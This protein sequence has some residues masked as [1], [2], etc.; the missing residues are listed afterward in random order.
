MKKITALVGIVFSLAT[1]PLYADEYDAKLNKLL[2]ELDAVNQGL[3][4]VADSLNPYEV[5]ALALGEKFDFDA[6]KTV[7]FVQKKIDFDSYAGMLR[8]EKGTLLSG[9]GNALDQSILLAVMLGDIGYDARIQNGLLSNG[10]A[11][12]LLMQMFKRTA[13]LSGLDKEKLEQGMKSIAAS[14][15]KPTDTRWIENID[16]AFAFSDEFENSTSKT[17]QI[18]YRMLQSNQ[19]KQANPHGYEA[20]L[21]EAKNYY[22]VEYKM[23]PQ[24]DWK[25]AHPAF[26][27]SMQPKKLPEVIETFNSSIPEKLQHRVRIELLVDIVESGKLK[28]RSLMA[29]F[30]RPAGN[31]AGIPLKFNLTPNNSSSKDVI[32]KSQFFIPQFNESIPA[33]A[34][35]FHKLGLLVDPKDIAGEVN[36]AA[37]LFASMAESS[38]EASNSLGS[39]GGGGDRVTQALASVYLQVTIISPGKKNLVERHFWLNRVYDKKNDKDFKLTKLPEGIDLFKKLTGS[40]TLMIG[41]GR[42]KFGFAVND[43]ATKVAEKKPFIELIARKSRWPDKSVEF[44]F[45]EW[46]SMPVGWPL[47]NLFMSQLLFTN[48]T[49][50]NSV[51]YRDAPFIAL[52]KQGASYLD[53]NGSIIDIISNPVRAYTT[54]Q[55]NI[56]WDTERVLKQGV[57]DTFNESMFS[58][59]DGYNAGKI[60]LDTL[61]ESQFI[62]KVSQIEALPIKNTQVKQ[63][64]TADVNL[65]YAILLPNQTKLERPGWWRINSSTGQVLGMIDNGLGG[66]FIEDLQL[67]INVNMAMMGCLDASYMKADVDKCGCAVAAGM[68]LFGSAVGN[69]IDNK[70]TIGSIHWGISSTLNNVFGAN[71]SPNICD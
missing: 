44:G 27:Q 21:K 9:S 58:G 32:L 41:V 49:K 65:G 25:T 36:G 54:T 6:N 35:A 17:S 19:T 1:T 52:H 10:D 23:G 5:D 61:F 47:A 68:F 57:Y 15:S 71:Y 16:T 40:I 69:S 48:E 13:F 53:E 43:Y 46:S 37:G 55:D 67:R 56:R 26:G 2:S 50:K 45:K 12:Q 63:A 8:G 14:T 22:W 30:E 20:L 7:G 4:Q 34:Q 18:L 24:D 59:D 70:M 29:K 66:E 3:I 39:M 64:L 28:T 42:Q 60:P 38:L 11:K 31:L 51:V 33:R 62:T